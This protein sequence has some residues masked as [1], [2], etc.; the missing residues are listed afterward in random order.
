MMDKK[1]PSMSEKDKDFIL[2]DM[3]RIERRRR[4]AGV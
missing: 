4:A 3:L 1:F 2:A